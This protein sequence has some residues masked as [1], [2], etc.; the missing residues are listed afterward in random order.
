MFVTGIVL[1][2]LGGVIVMAG[3][4]ALSLMKDSDGEGPCAA[5]LDLLCSAGLFAFLGDFFRAAS[6]AVRKPSSPEF[7]LVILVASG[8]VLLAIGGGLLWSGTGGWR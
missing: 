8:I 2:V 1:A 5:A 3:A 4:L 6:R 7:P